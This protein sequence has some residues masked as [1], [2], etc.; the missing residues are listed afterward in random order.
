MQRR[1][2]LDVVALYA[3]LEQAQYKV[4][5]GT[6]VRVTTMRRIARDVG[7]TSSTLTRMKRRGKPDADALVSLLDWLGADYRS[8]IRDP[9]EH[10][11]DPLIDVVRETDELGLYD[12][13]S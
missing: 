9:R 4:V 3:A 7:V 12:E 6:V 1:R 2:E 10:A 8:F 5:D 11:V 13:P